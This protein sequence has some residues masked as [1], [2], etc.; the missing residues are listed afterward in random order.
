[1]GSGFIYGLCQGPQVLSFCLSLYS[2]SHSGT[3]SDIP[4]YLKNSS[5]SSNE[6]LLG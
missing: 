5:P 6:A 3:I 2:G 4:N 1:M